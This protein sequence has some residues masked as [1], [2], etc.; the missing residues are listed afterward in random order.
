VNLVD[1]GE[2][3]FTQ[4]A[5]HDAR[6]RVQVV[7]NQHRIDVVDQGQFSP[8]RPCSRLASPHARQ[9]NPARQPGD[10][11]LHD[12]SGYQDRP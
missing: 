4:H 11:N 5:V 3:A 12:S 7:D 2:A 1:I 9:L 10:A 8:V 6:H